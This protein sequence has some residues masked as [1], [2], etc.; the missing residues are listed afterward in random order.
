MLESAGEC[1]KTQIV[2]LHPESSSFCKSG[3]GS[4]TLILNNFQLIRGLLV[5][6]PALCCV[7]KVRCTLLQELSVTHELCDFY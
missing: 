7:G 6:P 4:E 1:I 3:T 5:G 2:G